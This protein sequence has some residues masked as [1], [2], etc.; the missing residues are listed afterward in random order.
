MC[1]GAGGAAAGDGDH[2]AGRGLSGGIG[3]WDSG[4]PGRVARRSATM[5]DLSRRWTPERAARR[6]LWQR[7]AVEA[8]EG[9]GPNKNGAG[10]M[11]R[12]RWCAKSGSGRTAKPWDIAV[13]GG[14]ATGMGVAVDAAARGLERGAG[15]GARL[16]QGDQQP[17]HQAGA[18]R[19]AVPGAGQCSA[20][21]VGAERAR[22]D[23]PERAAP[24][25]RPGLRGAE[26]LL[27]GGAVLRHRAE[28]LRP[29]GGQVWLWRVEAAVERRNAGAAAGLEPKSCAAA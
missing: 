2:G 9:T 5:C 12:K 10:E 8:V 4:G 14:G 6:A 25:A 23:A 3:D 22:P 11:R 15:G 28:A 18:R 19:R 27:V 17:Q 21:D 24:G 13:I 29:A 20:G 16:W 1:W 7:G 26:L